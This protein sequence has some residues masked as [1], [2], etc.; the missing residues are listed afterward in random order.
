[1]RSRRDASL[2]HHCW[3]SHHIN[4]ITQT[5]TAIECNFVRFHARRRRICVFFE[6]VIPRKVRLES[7]RCLESRRTQRVT[8]STYWKYAPT[9][10]LRITFVVDSTTS[11]QSFRYRAKCRSQCDDRRLCGGSAN[12]LGVWCAVKLIDANAVYGSRFFRDDEAADHARFVIVCQ[13]PS[14][15]A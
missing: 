11:T 5:H 14:A 1:M 4:D 12:A 3:D 7:S 15:S 8:Q 13:A 10:C 2:T 6:F 9:R